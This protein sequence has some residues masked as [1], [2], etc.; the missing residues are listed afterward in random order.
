MRP[1]RWTV[2]RD[3]TLAIAERLMVHRRLR[4]LFVV[5]GG[6]LVGSISE[7]DILRY[8]AQAKS[9][10]TWWRDPVG[11]AIQEVSLAAGPDDAVAQAGDRL[12]ESR[13]DAL[14]V[15]ERGYL[16]GQVTAHDLL[17]LE[18]HE[19]TDAGPMTAGDVMTEPAVAI[20]PEDSLLVAAGLMAE[21]Q[22]RHLPVTEAGAV[23]GMLSDRDVRTAVGDPIRF[24]TGPETARLITV[25][26]AMTG[27]AITVGAH[28]PL[29]EL[30]A[31]F[32]DE[33]IGAV[34]V[35]DRERKLLGVV[36][37]VDVL[38]ALAERR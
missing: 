14:P 1:V 32:A 15:V 7:G 38:R 36:S 8:R 16:V 33:K 12:A 18:L 17:E 37:Y 24:T 27:P 31:K 4:S 34:P 9:D 21:H 19:R 30:A 25:R 22:L 13:V 10:Q 3:Q 35:I 28:T 5:D 26:D 23:I 20:T 2:G 29:A 6:K 11:R